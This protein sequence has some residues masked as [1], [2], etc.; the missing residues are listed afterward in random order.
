[1]WRPPLVNKT[2]AAVVNFD[3]G[4]H[5]YHYKEPSSGRADVP[6]EIVAED[7]DNVQEVVGPDAETPEMRRELCTT[8]IV[9]IREVLVFVVQVICSSFLLVSISRSDPRSAGAAG[10]I[11][12]H[13]IAIKCRSIRKLRKLR[14]LYIKL[15][16]FPKSR[17][18]RS[19][20]VED[21][22]RGSVVIARLCVTTTSSSC[23]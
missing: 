1:V 19:F 18:Q 11:H 21:L 15:A 5:T 8:R 14:I 3:A 20:A 2:A 10:L 9:N 17:T 16:K 12:F 7:E 13:N 6:H 22:G 4:A 23:P